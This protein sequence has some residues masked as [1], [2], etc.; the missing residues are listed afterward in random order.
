MTKT[1]IVIDDDELVN[2]S[3][4]N[5]LEIMEINVVGRGYDGKEAVDLFLKHAPDYSLIDL[6]MP[7]FDGFV[8]GQRGRTVH[9]GGCR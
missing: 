7:I 8:Q 9:D 1:A 5:L 2:E 4:T 6:A 3:L